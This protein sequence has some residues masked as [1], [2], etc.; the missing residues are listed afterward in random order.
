MQREAQIARLLTECDVF[1]RYGLR[2]KVVEQLHAVLDLDPH[3][4]EARE[5][6]KEQYLARG[7]VE[8]AVGQLLMLAEILAEERS[9][10]SVLYLRE[11]LVLDPTNAAAQ[12]HL[13]R[14][15]ASGEPS[16]ARRASVLEAPSG[17]WSGAA[18]E[19]IEDRSPDE[20]L[21]P[22]PPGREDQDDV[23]FLD[24]E[25]TDV[26]AA[27]PRTD[28][29]PAD[30]APADTAPAD[31]APPGPTD[32]TV[33][34]IARPTPLP[35]PLPAGAAEELEDAAPVAADADPPLHV[36]EDLLPPPPA[37][38]VTL[39][40]PPGAELRIPQPMVP[41][42]SAAGPESAPQVDL[43]APMTPEEFDEVPLRPSN[44]AMLAAEGARRS[45]A[46]GEI[47]ELLE[48]AEFFVAQGL[49]EEARSTLSDAFRSHP[50]HPLIDEK[51]RDVAQLAAAAEAER[52]ASSVGA[53]TDQSFELA[54]KLAAELDESEP[55]AAGSDV[56]DVEQVFEQFKKG[57]GEQ[58][59]VEDSET[60]FDLGIAYKEMGLVDDAINEF[61]L[62]LN[63]PQRVCIAE[64]MIGLCHIERGD[65]AQAIGHFKRGLYADTKTDR[66]ELGL[67]FELGNAYE[68]LH[69]PKEA[70]YYYQ[71]VH[72]RDPDFRGVVARI[73]ALTQPQSPQAP[74][75][76]AP[77]DIDRAF[78]DLMGE[79]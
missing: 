50:G 37:P 14:V 72:K 16:V 46:A 32:A 39:P 15:G 47:E 29:A 62:C 12:A 40:P 71:K 75:P 52:S 48:E 31:T 49:F 70:L 66:E 74:T 51:L 67:Y 44:P 17:V 78:D 60:H 3:H 1:M 6:L 19:P 65:V 24:E 20:L 59:A 77:D 56:L 54:E 34:A 69:D 11:A 25:N 18:A 55:N 5:R 7:E 30:T 21:P 76:M 63:D 53:P 28:T 68:L 64:T 73:Q 8:A 9:A 57:V 2:Q 45:T 61:R 42:P 10:A 38:R 58:V 36:D 27:A 43:L 4:V 13:A 23:F 41:P 35:T 26:V 33:A 79:D 22:M